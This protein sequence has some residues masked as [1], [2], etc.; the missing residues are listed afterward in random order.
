M[1]QGRWSPGN[2]LFAIGVLHEAV[3]LAGGAG[4][5]AMPGGDRRNL[6]AEL[7][8]AGVVGAVEPDPARQILFWYLFFGLLLLVLGRALHRWEAPGAPLPASV[9]WQLVAVA[10]AGGL[11]IPASGFWLALAPGLWV[12]RRARAAR[13]VAG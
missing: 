10:V 6:F 12:I 13:V 7:A 5:V 9:G 2:A 4:V 3:G 8:R 11:L 1:S